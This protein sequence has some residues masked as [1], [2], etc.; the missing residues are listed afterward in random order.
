MVAAAAAL[1]LGVVLIFLQTVDNFTYRLSGIVPFLP[2]STIAFVAITVGFFGIRFLGQGIM[3]MSSRNMV[4]KWFKRKRGLV[5]VILGISM[6]FGFT[7]SPRLLEQL[8]RSFGW[9]GAWRFMGL[10]V[11]VGFFLIVLVFFRDNPQA[12]GLEP[13]GPLAKIGPKKSVSTKD[14]LPIEAGEDYTLREARRTYPFWLFCLSLTLSSL[15][16][17]ALTFH[18][19]SIF[20]TAGMGR[21][22]AVQIFLPSAV[23]A[24]VLQ[25]IG[26]TLSDYIELKWFLHL[27]LFG[28]LLVLGALGFLHRGAPV[29][30]I[31]IGYGMISGMFGILSTIPWPNYYGLKHLGAISG[32]VMAFQVAGSAAG[33][34][35]FSLS[36][37]L[38]GRYSTAA[39]ISFAAAFILFLGSFRVKKPV[40]RLDRTG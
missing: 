12:C 25:V 32:L 33:P 30:M 17:T 39:F 6:S 21:E 5:N 36:F 35:L 3:T 19:V 37:T 28:M 23:V 10:I 38:S 20:Q 31:I 2:Y 26:S 18:V 22:V 11:G 7:S 29:W 16:I 27:Q 34:Y 14:E 8:I 24:V 13:D 15:T 4:M 9:R 40:R 1:G